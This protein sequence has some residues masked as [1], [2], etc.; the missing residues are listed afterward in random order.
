LR[1]AEQREG[2][3]E[4]LRIGP[5]GVF[6]V[7]ADAEDLRLQL[8]EAGETRLVRLKLAGSGGRVGQNVERQH[9]V[10]RAAEI[11]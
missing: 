1:V 7:D 2:D 4:L 5:V 3:A 9:Y 8:F 10:L 11:A 6:A